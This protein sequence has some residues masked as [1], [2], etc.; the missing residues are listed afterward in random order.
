MEEPKYQGLIFWERL[1]LNFPHLPEKIFEKSNNQNLVKSREVCQ[2]W[3]DFVKKS[4][5]YNCRIIK[6][7]TN[8]SDELMKD[9]AKTSKDAIVIASNLD[10]I[11]KKFPKGTRQ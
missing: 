7:Y 5:L 10:A 11:F 8:C 3:N 2:A 9:L 6:N 4:K 1:F